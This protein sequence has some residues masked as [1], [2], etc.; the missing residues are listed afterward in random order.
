MSAPLVSFCTPT[1]NRPE[2]LRRTVQSCLAQ[3]YPH[4]ELI[5]TD[6]STNDESAR[7]LSQIND[8]RIRYYSNN[9]NIGSFANH[10]RAV[11]LAQGKYQQI[12]A[13]DDLLKPKFLELMVNAF[14]KHP[15]VGVLMAPMALIDE[16]DKRIFPKFYLI[17][18]MQYR[19][20]YQV[21]DGL[22]ERKRLLRDFLT[23]AAGDY[24]CC[25]PSG[26]LYRA[27]AFQSALP[28]DARADFA[29]DLDMCMKVAPHWDFYYIDQVLSSWRYTPTNHTAR[30]HKEGLPIQAFYFVTRRCLGNRAVQDMF[31][32]E[33]D[34]L[35]RDSLLFCTWRAAVLNSLAAIRAR[36]PKLL[37]NT[38]KTIYQE[39]PYRTNLLRLPICAVRQIVNSFFPPKRTPARE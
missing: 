30:L 19:Y 32:D 5:I 1:Y 13:D 18:T 2:F 27:E 7:M 4:F 26:I 33:W 22:I 36:S 15:T 14:E 16:N 28:L 24:P 11:S 3:T 10:T 20:R 9:G 39:D 8:P 34:K 31:Q 12:L 35:R 21:G 17:H 37:T 38:I 25:V 29:G 23:G 6:N